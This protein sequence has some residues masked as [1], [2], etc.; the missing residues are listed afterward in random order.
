MATPNPDALEAEIRGLEEQLL[1][2]EVRRSAERMAELLA[3]DFVEF[4]SSG[5]AYD[6]RRILEVLQDEALADDPVTRSLEK[7][8]VI[9]LGTDVVLTRYRLLRQHSA[10]EPPTQSMRSSVWRRR[11]GRWQML[12]HQG[13]YV[14][15]R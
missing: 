1:E 3:D 5:V 6:K 11:D 13:T 4:A 2:P 8:E 9:P 14:A 10:H 7:F 12:F 15:G